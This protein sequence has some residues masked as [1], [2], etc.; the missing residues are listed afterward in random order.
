MGS[1]SRVHVSYMTACFTC[2]KTT[3]NSVV[4]EFLLKTFLYRQAS[5]L[6]PGTIHYNPHYFNVAP[7]SDGAE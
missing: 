5:P 6:H 1:I 2:P 3:C 7:S 4:K